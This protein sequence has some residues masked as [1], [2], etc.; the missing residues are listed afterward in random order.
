MSTTTVKFCKTCLTPNSRP[1]VVFDDNGICNACLNAQD[2][3]V[4]DWKSRETQFKDL[5]NELRKSDLNYHCIVPWSGGKDS[6]T[7]A[8]KLKFDFGLNPLLVTYSPMIPN[9]IAIKEMIQL[10]S[11][12]T[13]RPIK[14]FLDI[15]LND[16]Y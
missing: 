3:Q 10:D 16:F 4:I 12:I 7:I 11:I 15:W 5:A 14:M 6:S 2:K 13:I 9:D 1:R 8:Y